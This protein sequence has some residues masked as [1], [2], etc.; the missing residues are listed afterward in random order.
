M[1][2][3]LLSGEVGEVDSQVAEDCRLE[4]LAVECSDTIDL[5]YQC[6][7]VGAILPCTSRQQRDDFDV[8]SSY[9]K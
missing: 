9:A 6:A 5:E 2:S 7:A 1:Y 4:K 3:T 8:R